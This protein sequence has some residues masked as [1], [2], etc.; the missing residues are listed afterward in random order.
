FEVGRA[1]T[2]WTFFPQP[3][4]TIPMPLWAAIAHVAIGSSLVLL[5][6]D[7]GTRIGQRVAVA[8]GLSVLTL[9]VLS[10]AL[11]ITMTSLPGATW[12]NESRL[13]GSV[14][15]GLESC[16]LLLTALG[17]RRAVANLLALAAMTI[18]GVVVLGYLYG[19]PLIDR[20]G[21]A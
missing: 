7:D 9:V 11:Q 3:P 8:T 4:G 21:I 2:G 16:A 5:A 1:F 12:L 15:R 10:I 13:I 19:G 20:G 17:S 14:T 6:R 18:G